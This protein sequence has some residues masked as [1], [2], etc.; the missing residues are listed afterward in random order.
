[1]LSQVKNKVVRVRC[2]P[3]VNPSSKYKFLVYKN[4]KI[5]RDKIRK[6]QTI[7]ILQTSQLG[8]GFQGV[9]KPGFARHENYKRNQ[10]QKIH[11]DLPH[12][13]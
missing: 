4:F 2:R 12:C 9:T 10:R 13:F 5:R 8:Q 7:T 3:A 11:K 1:M 6:S